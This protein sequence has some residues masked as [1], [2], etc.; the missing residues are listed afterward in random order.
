MNQIPTPSDHGPS[1]TGRFRIRDGYILRQIVGEY[2][3]VPVASEGVMANGMMV[4]NDSAVFLWQAFSTPSTVDE[5]VA[6]G[7]LEYEVE[8][9]TLRNAVHRFVKELLFYQILEEMD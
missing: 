4:P 6:K 3:I 8:E 9:D 1:L 2:V 7:L 5:V